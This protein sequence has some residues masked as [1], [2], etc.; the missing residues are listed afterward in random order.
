MNTDYVA[1]LALADPEWLR[2]AQAF[3]KRYELRA[4]QPATVEDIRMWEQRY[5]AQLP[6]DYVHFL[7]T[8]GN[9]LRDEDGD[10]I[11]CGIPTHA[12]LAAKEPDANS[13]DSRRLKRPFTPEHEMGAGFDAQ[14]FEAEGVDD[15]D[16]S[17]EELAGCDGSDEE[18]F[19][20]KYDKAIEEFLEEAGEVEVAAEQGT[21]VIG[22]YS[23]SKYLLVIT[24]PQRGQVWTF[25]TKEGHGVS[26]GIVLTPEDSFCEWLRRGSFFR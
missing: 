3:I 9:G 11:L 19:M 22:D 26:G 25:E 13:S 16:L 20:L 18:I 7:L 5:E 12:E 17:E 2:E 14:E 24:G 10:E 1:L 6:T 4:M 15:I 21:L 23:L 8:I